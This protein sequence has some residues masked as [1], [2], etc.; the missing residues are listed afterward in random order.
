MTEQLGRKKKKKKK[1]LGEHRHFQPPC[2]TS[3]T[4]TLQ[5]ER[6][7]DL[8]AFCTTTYTFLPRARGPTAPFFP[9]GRPGTRAA[10]LGVWLFCP[11]RDGTT[12]FL[13]TTVSTLFF[14]VRC[15]CICEFC[16]VEQALDAGGSRPPPGFPLVRPAAARF[17]LGCVLVPGVV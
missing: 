9:G 7:P 11:V 2:M 4:A 15:S 10:D 16:S 3:P 1:S 5:A 13:V 12:T 6:R 8:S 17:G 14:F